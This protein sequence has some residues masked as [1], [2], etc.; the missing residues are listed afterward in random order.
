MFDL[1]ALVLESKCTNRI[2]V[3]EQ[4]IPDRSRY[5]IVAKT[6]SAKPPSLN[7]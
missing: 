5:A 4:R 2:A 6:S 3:S 1:L 7:F